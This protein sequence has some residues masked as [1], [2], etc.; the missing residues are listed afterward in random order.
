MSSNEEYTKFEQ[1]TD[2]YYFIPF[3]LL[4]RVFKL[5]SADLTA[6]G[7]GDGDGDG[8]G[9]GVEFISLE[10]KLVVPY[11]YFLIFR[12]FTKVDSRISDHSISMRHRNK[13]GSKLS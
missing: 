8:D 11:Q 3:S 12:C 10:T 4:R 2:K 6:V 7:G 5:I 1:R 13:Q 9:A